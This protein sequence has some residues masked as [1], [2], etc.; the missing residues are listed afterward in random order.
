MATDCVKQD[1]AAVRSTFINVQRTRN[2]SERYEENENDADTNLLELSAFSPQ[3]RRSSSAHRKNSTEITLNQGMELL[4][5]DQDMH[6]DTVSEKSPA[7]S[8]SPNKKLTS[9]LQTRGL[10]GRKIKRP[11]FLE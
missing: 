3:R 9:R 8:P 4:K 7:H 11:E 10:A 1:K 6:A 2:S 5:S